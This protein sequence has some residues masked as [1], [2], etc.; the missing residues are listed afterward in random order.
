MTHEDA[1]GLAGRRAM[2]GAAGRGVRLVARQRDDLDSMAAIRSAM[3][4]CVAAGIVMAAA[5]EKSAAG[6]RASW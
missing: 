4:C 1:A 3:A 2:A 5:E 6:I